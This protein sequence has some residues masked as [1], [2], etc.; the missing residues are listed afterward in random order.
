[1]L[2]RPKK[3][4]SREKQYRIRLNDK[5]DKM[6]TFASDATGIPKSE[7]F[8]KAL[9]EYCEKVKLQQASEEIGDDTTWEY[10][11]ISLQRAIECPYCKAKNRIDLENE[12]IISTSE[13]QMGNEVLYEFENVEHQCHSCGR[14]FTVSGYITEYPLGAFNAES[15]KVAPIEPLP[16]EAK[17]PIICRDCGAVLEMDAKQKLC[18][19]CREKRKAKWMERLKAGA[20]IVGIIGVAVGAAYLATKGTND[21]DESTDDFEPESLD[22]DSDRKF[23]LRVKYPDGTEEEE[24]ELFD[25]EEE[26][27]AYG[28]YIISCSREGA[29]TLNMSNSGDYPLEDYEDPDY[30]VIA[31]E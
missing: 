19:N 17:H 15:L 25:S 28:D 11:R 14:A 16:G 4:D 1:M 5:E 6:L 26:A 21:S 8:R 23:K 20:K 18:P 30:E 27:K 9:Q 12:G 2:G 29:E 31:T 7:I 13:R 10:D 24:D 22:N 3:E